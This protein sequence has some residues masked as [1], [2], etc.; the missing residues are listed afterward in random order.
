MNTIIAGFIGPQEII[1]IF[2]SMGLVL[3]ILVAVF[4]IFRS[5][6]RSKNRTD[7]INYYKHPNK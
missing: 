4:I 3:F 1:V 6:K 2:L 7:S 5:T